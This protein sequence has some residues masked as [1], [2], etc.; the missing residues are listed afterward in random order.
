V[1]AS[2]GLARQGTIHGAAQDRTGTRRAFE[3]AQDAML[4]ADRADYRP[5]CAFYDQAELDSLALSAHLALGDHSTAEYHAHRCLSALRPHMIRS[6]A[7]TT[8]RL[9]HAQLAQGAHD[10]A[11]ATAMKVPAE[12][13]T[14]H[15]R[16]TR[17][18]VPPTIAGT[19]RSGVPVP[20]GRRHSLDLGGKVNSHPA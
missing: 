7:I 3:Q 6:R 16:L 9:A 4:R 8:I 20:A 17:M 1:F 12:A 19:R 2:L 14:Q 11:T 13:A 18:K 15:A 10:A 5:V